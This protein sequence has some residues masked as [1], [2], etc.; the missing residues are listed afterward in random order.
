MGE[1]MTNG[2]DWWLY[3]SAPMVIGHVVYRTSTTTKFR[4][5]IIIAPTFTTKYTYTL[6]RGTIIHSYKIN[7]H[8]IFH[9]H[10]ISLYIHVFVISHFFFLFFLFISFF[11]HFCRL[12][13]LISFIFAHFFIHFYNIYN[14]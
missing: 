6:C 5:P 10:F 13:H 11:L 9:T 1:S 3:G 2:L 7:I 14:T 4:Q 8:C 12:Y